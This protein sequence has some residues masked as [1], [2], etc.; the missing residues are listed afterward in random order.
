MKMPRLSFTTK[1]INACVRAS[2]IVLAAT[3]VMLLIGRGTLGETVI[4]LLYLVPIGWSTTRWGQGPGA[5]AAVIAA[6]CF[7]FF[8]IPPFFTFNVGSLEGWLV[9]IIFFVVAVVII[10]RI[11]Y[12]LSQAQVRE[13]EAVF[14]YELSI[15]LAGLHRPDDIA[16]A[17]A[18]H[19][20]QIFR[21]KFVQVI[22]EAIGQPSL[23][24]SV[25]QQAAANGHPDRI[26]PL[27]APR[28]LIGEICLWRDEAPLPPTD[29]RL[30]QNFAKQ[31][32]LALERARQFQVEYNS[33]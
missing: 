28:G 4:A 5:C 10:G 16:H 32:A 19:V 21:A 6:L 22:V 17:L 9:L 29:N 13:R 33:K 20:Q 27:M 15:L 18:Q 25:P 30:L 7:D 26:V 14:M 2:L 31:G 24:I 23:V 3:A 12:G 11:Q 1:M 8:F